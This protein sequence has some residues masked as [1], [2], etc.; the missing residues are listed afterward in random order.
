MIAPEAFKLLQN[1]ALLVI[2]G[3]PKDSVDE[4]K[5]RGIENFIHIKSNVLLELK[6]YDELLDHI[7]N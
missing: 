3:Y 1:K 6:K 5:R 2:A 4:L 7:T